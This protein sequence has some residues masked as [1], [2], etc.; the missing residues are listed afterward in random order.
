[1]PLQ[2]SE[3]LLKDGRLSDLTTGG[4]INQKIGWSLN[5]PVS[6]PRP[7][8]DALIKDEEPNWFTFH[9]PW[10]STHPRQAQSYAYFCLPIK[11][12]SPAIFDVWMAPAWHDDRP[13]GAV[14]TSDNIDVLM[15][16]SL[17]TVYDLVEG[18]GAL[19]L[20]SVLLQAA[21]DQR[22]ARQKG[23]SDQFED[24]GLSN[25]GFSTISTTYAI[26][27]EIKRRLPK[28][29]C[30]W[31]FLRTITKLLRQNRTDYVMDL[32][33]VDGN[34]IAIAQ[35]A[36]QVIDIGRKQERPARI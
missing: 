12:S 29:G 28:E 30:K 36:M 6:V 18:P 10:S 11:R 35:H 17:P 7:S 24:Q 13:G 9:L 16:L 1:M 22:A 34:L 20:Y 21:K 2:L 31:L 27:C 14:W 33:D 26:S 5:P 4:L 23:K 8:F 25:D 15:D 32:L 19:P 3:I